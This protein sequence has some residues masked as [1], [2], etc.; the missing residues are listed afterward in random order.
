MP[1]EPDGPMALVNGDWIIGKFKMLDGT[2]KYLLCCGKTKM[3]YFASF[4][5]AR[6]AAVL[7]A[8]EEMAGSI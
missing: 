6:S 4:E 1:W 8:A 3:G 5:E 7:S 2:F